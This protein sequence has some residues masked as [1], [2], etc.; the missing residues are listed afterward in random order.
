MAVKSWG[1]GLEIVSSGCYFKNGS[2][3]KQIAGLFCL[4]QIIEQDKPKMVPKDYLKS[5][6]WNNKGETGSAGQTCAE[7]KR[8]REKAKIKVHCGLGDTEWATVKSHNSWLL[9]ECH[10]FMLCTSV[11]T[12]ERF[13]I[14]GPWNYLVLPWDVVI[15]RSG[16]FLQSALPRPTSYLNRKWIW[17]RRAKRGGK[18]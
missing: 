5:N 13:H 10:F 8:K 1:L 16:L 7:Q 3:V 12:C 18:T 2:P 9:V 4:E 14:Q 15:N 17:G 6:G 11:G